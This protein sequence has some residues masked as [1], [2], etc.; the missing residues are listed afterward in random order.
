[1]FYEKDIS[2]FNYLTDEKNLFYSQIIYLILL[3]SK[4]YINQVDE[5]NGDF[6]KGCIELIKG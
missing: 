4:V 1:M 2:L 6:D 3:K 5:E